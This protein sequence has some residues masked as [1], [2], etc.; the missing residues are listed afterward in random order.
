[1]KGALTY[2]SGLLHSTHVEKAGLR[3]AEI[4]LFCLLSDRIIDMCHP[5][6]YRFADDVT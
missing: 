3:F 6:W 1:V 5:A 4:L 2:E